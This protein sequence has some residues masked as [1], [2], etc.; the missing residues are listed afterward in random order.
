M[1]ISFYD[2]LGKP[3]DVSRHRLSEQ[4]VQEI[5]TIIEGAEADVKFYEELDFKS[6][7]KKE[8]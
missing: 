1:K 4:I 6:T 2:N 5:T 3:V 8:A 7:N